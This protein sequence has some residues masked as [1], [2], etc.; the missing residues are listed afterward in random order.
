MIVIK[1]EKCYRCVSTDSKK[2]TSCGRVVCHWHQQAH[3]CYYGSWEAVNNG[4]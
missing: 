2:C 4:I 1:S 3:K